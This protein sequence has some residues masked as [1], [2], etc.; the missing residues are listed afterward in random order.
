MATIVGL[1]LRVGYPRAGRAMREVAVFPVS[2]DVPDTYYGEAEAEITFHTLEGDVTCQRVAL[3]RNGQPM[4]QN[5]AD[6]HVVKQIRGGR[7]RA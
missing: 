3:P 7:G 1:E 6:E 2:I 5:Q 4:D